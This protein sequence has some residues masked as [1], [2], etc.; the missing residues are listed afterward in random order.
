MKRIRLIGLCL[1][2]AFAMSAAAVATASAAPDY[3]RCKALTGGKYQD[4]GCTIASVPGKEKYEWYPWGS[5]LP[6]PE[7]RG[8]TTK[9][10]GKSA[11]LETVKGAKVVC[12]S[13]TGAGEI[14]YYN[15]VI[16]TMTF[17]GCTSAGLPCTTSGQAAGTIVGG[18]AYDYLVFQSGKQGGRM[19][20]EGGYWILFECAGGPLASLHVKIYYA[21]ISSPVK[22]GKMVTKETVKYTATKGKQVPDE[23]ETYGSG[24]Y[25]RAQLWTPAEEFIEEVQTGLTMTV[26]QKYNEKW[27]I[28]PVL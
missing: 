6:T 3:G 8:V 13:E 1:V 18:P 10:K 20:Y 12:T 28:N 9:L 23:N 4:K 7:N 11:T 5:G 22:L 2:A 27:E 17:K 25:L 24:L 16:E 15:Y 26:I 21:A 14:A 19:L